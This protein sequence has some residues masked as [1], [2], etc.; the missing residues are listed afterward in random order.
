MEDKFEDKYP[1]LT[2]M[3]SDFYRSAAVYMDKEIALNHSNHFSMEVSNVGDKDF[4]LR[5]QYGF[6]QSL[7]V[8]MQT[9]CTFHEG[10]CYEVN[11]TKFTV[12]APP[13]NQPLLNTDYTINGLN[14]E[15]SELS[16]SVSSAYDGLGTIQEYSSRE[17]IAGNPN[18]IKVLQGAIDDLRTALTIGEF[19]ANVEAG[20]EWF[21]VSEGNL[22]PF[23]SKDSAPLTEGGGQVTIR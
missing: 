20:S 2:Q 3:I 18:A 13:P 5:I 10:E 17:D 16:V 12:F 15:M 19:N 9:D 1:K 6:P 14:P 22:S 11:V 4:R 21:P 8:S 7:C 23:S